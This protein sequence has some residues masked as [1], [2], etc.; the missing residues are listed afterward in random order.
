MPPTMLYPIEKLDVNQIA[1]PIEEVRK[2]NRQRFEMEQ[3]DG[4]LHY[5]PENGIVVGLKIVKPDE[6]WVRGHIPGRPLLPGVLMCECA[7]QTCSFLYGRA[8]GTERFLGF[9][10]LENVKFRGQVVPG[11]KIMMM[12]KSAEVRSRRAQFQ[13]QGVVNG[14]LVFE[15][16][17]IGM[18]I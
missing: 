10:G 7:A 3:L 8:M 16:V 4:I 11:D 14:K 1:I 12:A 6:F 17:I 9:G 15:G 18:P 5:D 2:V 13:T